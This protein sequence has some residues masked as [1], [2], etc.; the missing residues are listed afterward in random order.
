MSSTPV[1]SATFGWRIRRRH[2]RRNFRG[3]IRSLGGR[4]LMILPEGGRHTPCGLL[5]TLLG[6]RSFCILDLF[7]CFGEVL[8]H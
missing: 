1:E 6:L 2:M 5:K 4:S 7:G 3:R 8:S